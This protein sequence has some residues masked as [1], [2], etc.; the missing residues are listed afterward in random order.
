MRCALWAVSKPDIHLCNMIRLFGAMFEIAVRARRRWRSLLE[1]SM[2]RLHAQPCVCVCVCF[3][4]GKS[5]RWGTNIGEHYQNAS[6]DLCTWYRH[7]HKW[8]HKT[9]TFEVR[10]VEV[11]TKAAF[12]LQVEVLQDSDLI[13]VH[14]CVCACLHNSHVI[15]FS[16]LFLTTTYVLHTNLMFC[17]VSSIWTGKLKMRHKT[18]CHSA[19]HLARCGLKKKKPQGSLISL[20]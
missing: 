4:P 20:D 8:Q 13:C 14:A 7:V 15:F 1:W 9:Q 5:G 16:V 18:W 12:R 3:L 2:K 17:K 6:D 11:Q 10:N 19:A